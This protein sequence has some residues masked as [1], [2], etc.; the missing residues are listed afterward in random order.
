[1]MK[2][3]LKSLLVCLIVMSCEG[4]D[5]P[6]ELPSCIEDQI[7]AEV[8]NSDV[9]EPQKAKVEAYLYKGEKVYI[10]DPGSGYADWLY[11]AYN[12]DCEVICQ[13]GGFAGMNTCPDFNEHSEYLGVVW[14]DPR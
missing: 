7:K 4:L 13:F 12:S 6:G 2:T 1:M 14:E 5:I 11:T 10:F 9:R 8:K 3:L